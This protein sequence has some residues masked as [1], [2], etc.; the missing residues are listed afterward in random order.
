G[1]HVIEVLEREEREL[2]PADYRFSQ[3]LAYRN[4]LDEARAAAA[5][6]DF[7][8]I[9]KAP[10]DPLLEGQQSQGPQLP[11]QQGP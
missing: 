5:V 8:S 9:D 10:E 2:T 1:W 11:P 7:W 6:E 3:Q 4:W